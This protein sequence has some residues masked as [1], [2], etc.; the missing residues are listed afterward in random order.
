[1]QRRVRAGQ[2]DSRA[3]TTFRVTCVPS[4]KEKARQ[5]TNGLRGSATTREGGA[6]A[7]LPKALFAVHSVSS[8]SP[9]HLASPTANAASACMRVS[10]TSLRHYVV[11]PLAEAAVTFDHERGS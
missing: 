5:I 1:M 10:G 2:Q 3:E 9:A 7:Q 11:F 8:V 6:H 4:R